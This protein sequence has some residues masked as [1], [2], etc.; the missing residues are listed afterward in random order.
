M[1]NEGSTASAKE[2]DPQE[3][4]ESLCNNG[5]E[6]DVATTALALGREDTEIREMLSGDVPVDSD[7]DMKVHGLAQERGIDLS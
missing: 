4:L 5:F 2:C 6:G 7:L 1:N 3:C